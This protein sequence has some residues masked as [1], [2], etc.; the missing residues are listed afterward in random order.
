MFTD[1]MVPF[2]RLTGEPS[3]EAL[4]DDEVVDDGDKFEAFGDVD[5]LAPFE[6]LFMLN[7]ASE[8]VIS[9]SRLFC[10]YFAI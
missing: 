4:D 3:D 2:N 9:I 7:R 5:E 6:L 10:I 1:D 8:L